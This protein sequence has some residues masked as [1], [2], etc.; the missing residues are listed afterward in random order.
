MQPHLNKISLLPV[1][2]IPEIR[3]NDN[4]I[5]ILVNSVK[6][7]N[8]E[9]KENDIIVVAQ[10]IISKAENRIINLKEVIPSNFAK[11]VSRE[12]SKDPKLVEI[13]L[14]ETKKII[15]MDQRKKNKGRLIV[16]TRNGLILANAGVDTSNVSGGNSVTLLPLDPDNSAEKIKR[17]IKKHLGKNVAAIISDTVGRPWRDGLVDIAIGCAGIRALNDQRGK[18]DSKG[19]KLNATVMATAD[20]IAAAAGLLMEKNNS[21]PVVIVRGL[22][23]NKNSRGSRELIRNPKE[24]LFR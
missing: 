17:G 21:T 2:H 20:Q 9:I 14:N 11:T 15:K 8:I 18:K 10:K 12:V 4:L 6:K 5:K 3:P 24:D 7:N 16:E 1:D 19:F 23:F 13:I 22:R